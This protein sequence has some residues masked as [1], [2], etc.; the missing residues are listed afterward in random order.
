MQFKL[1]ENLGEQARS[2]LQRRC[3]QQYSTFF[4]NKEITS[5]KFL[6]L[7]ILNGHRIIIMESSDEQSVWA[8]KFRSQR[9]QNMVPPKRY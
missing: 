5:K 1:P 3:F 2:Q 7:Y 9:A 4:G 8:T 6:A